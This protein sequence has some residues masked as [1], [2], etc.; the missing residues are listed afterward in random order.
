MVTWTSAM[1]HPP[2]QTTCAV[3]G[4]GELPSP[5][6]LARSVPWISESPTAVTSAAARP[7]LSVA[8]SLGLLSQSTPL[9][10]LLPPAERQSTVVVSRNLPPIPAKLVEKIGRREYVDLDQLL[11]A[12][13]GD[14]ESTLGDLVAGGKKQK[15][16]K[17]ISS[18]QEWVVCFNA[19]SNSADEGT[20]SMQGLASLLLAD[21]QS[22]PGL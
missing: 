14:P 1:Y 7:V 19:Y 6:I 10:Q 22:Q 21:C 16:K 5:S 12:K 20:R 9:E 4:V 17:G 8:Q 3:I 11:P 2:I 13:L 18:I 15:E